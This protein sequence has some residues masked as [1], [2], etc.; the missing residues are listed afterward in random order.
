MLFLI[1]IGVVFLLSITALVLSYTNWMR[2]CDLEVP[3]WVFGVISLLIILVAGGCAL[4]EHVR[5]DAYLGEYTIYTDSL[6]H[7]IDE[8]YYATE[9]V[10]GR[11]EVIKEATEWNMKVFHNQYVHEHS[12]WFSAFVGDYWME[13]PLINLE[14]NNVS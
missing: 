6:Q 4:D 1:I 2:F 12:I 14:G 9:Y 5:S 7:Q 8:M 3:G 13:L 11:A 10:D